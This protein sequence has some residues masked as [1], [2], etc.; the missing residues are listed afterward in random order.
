MTFIG[1]K[2]L[3]LAFFYY[4][5]YQNSLKKKLASGDFINRKLS[6]VLKI[7]PVYC[8]FKLF[9]T[10]KGRIRFYIHVDDKLENGL[11]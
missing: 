7:W 10:K 5:E 1:F 6:K 3:C 11:E 2:M 9:Q 8:K 4:F